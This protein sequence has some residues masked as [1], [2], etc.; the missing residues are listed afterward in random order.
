MKVRILVGSFAALALQIASAGAQGAPLRAGNTADVGF[1]GGLAGV[2]CESCIPHDDVAMSGFV[3]VGR[4]LTPTVIASLEWARWARAQF[5]QQ[6]RFDFVTLGAQWYMMPPSGLWTRYAIG[7]GRVA[8]VQMPF[9]TDTYR[10]ERAG[11]AYNTS[12]GYDLHVADRIV[13]GPFVTVSTM[14]GGARVNGQPTAYDVSTSLFQYG[15]SVG[16]R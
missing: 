5:D 2:R 4:V 12:I 6:S 1:G 3:R 14:R 10:T 16:L 13:V 8:F 9:A 11:L 15:I 7:Y